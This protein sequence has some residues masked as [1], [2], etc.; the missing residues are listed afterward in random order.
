MGNESNRPKTP[1]YLVFYLLF[2]TDFWRIVMGVVAS[3]LATPR[4]VPP[5]FSAAGRAMLYVM[6]AAIAWT[7]TA[8]PARW[9]ARGVKKAFLGNRRR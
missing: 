3:I 4:I 2:S 5:D 8:V 7:I 9:I 1:T 6:V